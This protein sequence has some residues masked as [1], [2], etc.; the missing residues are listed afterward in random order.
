MKKSTVHRKTV[1]FQASHILF[2]RN[3]YTKHQKE[4]SVICGFFFFV[5]KLNEI[6]FGVICKRYFELFVNVQI[7]TVFKSKGK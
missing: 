7:V 1:D 2:G 6:I 3:K 4:I 5:K